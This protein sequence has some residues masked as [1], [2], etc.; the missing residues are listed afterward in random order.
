LLRLAEQSLFYF[1]LVDVPN[2]MYSGQK[3][4]KLIRIKM[5]AITKS[6]IATVTLMMW[7]K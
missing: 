4:I 6:I 3:I 2:G 5:G 7:V 1:F